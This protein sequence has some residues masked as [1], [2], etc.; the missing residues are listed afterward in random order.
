MGFLFVILSLTFYPF[1]LNRTLVLFASAW[2]AARTR[3]SLI[4]LLGWNLT[5]MKT[6]LV[7]MVVSSSFPELKVNTFHNF[8]KKCCVKLTLFYG[9][10]QISPPQ[11]EIPGT[12]KRSPLGQ[13]DQLYLT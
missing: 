11:E 7:S 6:S 8:V 5:V 13:E 1:L 9:D 10:Y 4:P 3:L 2:Q 12:N